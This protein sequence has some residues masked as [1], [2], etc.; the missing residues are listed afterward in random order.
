M[1]ETSTEAAPRV[2]QLW[3]NVVERLDPPT[4][5]LLARC[6]ALMLHGS[7]VMV[8]APD[9]FTRER[10]ENRLR[11]RIE[12]VLSDEVGRQVRI[13][14]NLDPPSRGTFPRRP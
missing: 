2:D 14:I 10:M 7:T 13:A 5:A 8:S 3:T 4:R 12:E 1:E 11:S 9:E 6:R